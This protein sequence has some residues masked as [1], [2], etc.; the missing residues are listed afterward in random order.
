MR[1][2][3]DKKQHLLQQ[4]NRLNHNTERTSKINFFSGIS[5]Y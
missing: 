3:L 5:E 4:M 2:L 1:H